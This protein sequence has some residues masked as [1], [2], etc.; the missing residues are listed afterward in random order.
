MNWV[1]MFHYGGVVTAILFVTFM[2]I[3]NKEKCKSFSVVI[4]VLQL[5]F[6][7]TMA[8]KTWISLIQQSKI[9]SDIE[10]ALNCANAAAFLLPHWL[11]ALQYLKTSFILPRLHSIA[12]LLK[13][14]RETLDSSMSLQSTSSF[15]QQEKEIEEI[16]KNQ[17]TKI[18]T[19]KSRMLFVTVTF[20]VLLVALMSYLEI[21]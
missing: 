6:N 15:M 21:Y 20:S 13:K 3:K 19:I 18:A 14:S 5:Y 9:D 2:L 7:I 8:L 4:I 12:L 16:V 17:K 10:T 11:Y 1:A